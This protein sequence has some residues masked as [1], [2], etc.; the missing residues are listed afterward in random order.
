MKQVL[1]LSQPLRCNYGCL[2]QAFALQKVVKNLGFEV[3]T[4]STFLKSK[5]RIT[6]KKIYN[7]SIRKAKEVAKIILGYN[8]LTPQKFKIISQ[9][10]QKFIDKYI[11]TE[12]IDTITEEQ[13]NRFDIFIV[14]SDQVFRKQYSPVTA[15]FLETLKD[16]NYK[17]KLAYAASFGTDDLSEWTQNEIEICKTLAP[18]FN[19]I[20]VREDSGVEIFKRYFDTKAELVLD[21]TL[22]LEKDDYLNTIDEKNTAIKD[23]VLMCYVLDKTPE[24]THIIN[25]I[26][27]QTGLNLLEIMPE[28]TFN[29]NT[30]DITKCIYPSVSKWLAGFRDASFVITDSFHGTVFSIIFNKPFVCI[31]NKERGLS[32]FTSLLKI[33]GLENRLIFSPED[34]SPNLLDNIDYNKVNSVKREWQAMSIKFLQDN[35]NK[36]CAA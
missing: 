8:R 20:S 6:V 10:T 12:S 17:I 7:F 28:E 26:K 22:L 2:L 33:F 18:K 36:I 35:I 30:K 15:Y 27:E 1:I 3:V 14:G 11:N 23:N 31:A 29:K 34:L 24:K 25:Q 5:R 32:R 21:P 16:I 13:I 4:N 19:A 9:N